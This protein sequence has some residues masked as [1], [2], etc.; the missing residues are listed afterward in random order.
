MLATGVRRNKSK[1][2]KNRNDMKKILMLMVAAVVLVGC[3]L[4]GKYLA[5]KGEKEHTDSVVVSSDYGRYRMVVDVPAGDNE[6]LQHAVLEFVT[7]I[8]GGTY[9]GN[10]LDVQA[11]LHH[12]V[13]T[14]AREYDAEGK[15]NPFVAEGEML[16]ESSVEIRKD[17][18][19]DSLV[20]YIYKMYDFQGGPHGTSVLSGQTF[21]K[22]DGQRVTWD[23]FHDVS[24]P[25]MAQLLHDGLMDYFEAANDEE[26]QDCLLSDD[27]S[28]LPLPGTPPLFTADGI[29]FVYEPY[30]IA[31]YSAGMPQFTVP[32]EKMKELER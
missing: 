7:E 17:F 22:R 26:L 25:A 2:Y 24:H 1:E 16:M 32:Y 15:E 29:L 20:T 13:D 6:A 27:V 21:R 31:P 5:T 23:A 4:R 11:M 10:L 3:G 14:I 8:S 9:T 12:Y 18:E 19:N 28:S 30:E